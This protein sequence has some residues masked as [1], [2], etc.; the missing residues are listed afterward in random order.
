MIERLLLG[1]DRLPVSETFHGTI[2]IDRVHLIN[3]LVQR[4]LGLDQLGK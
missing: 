4:F 1:D 2:T 3:F